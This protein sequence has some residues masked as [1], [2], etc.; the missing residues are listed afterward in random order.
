MEIKKYSLFVNSKEKDYLVGTDDNGN[1]MKGQFLILCKKGAMTL[2]KK[3]RE[4]LISITLIDVERN[5]I[6]VKTSYPTETNIKS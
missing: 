5:Q 1:D 4:T 6:I 3:V 2:P